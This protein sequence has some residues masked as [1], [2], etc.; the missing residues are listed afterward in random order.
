MKHPAIEQLV[1]YL[2]AETGLFMKPHLKRHLARCEEC[3]RKLKELKEADLLA[4]EL[5]QSIETFPDT[6]ETKEDPTFLEISEAFRD[7]S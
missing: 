1:K 4:E 7:K 3:S 6:D 2:N 5:K